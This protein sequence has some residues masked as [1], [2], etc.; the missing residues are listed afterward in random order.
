MLEEE[1]SDLYPS[2]HLYVWRADIS[3]LFQAGLVKKMVSDVHFFFFIYCNTEVLA[4]RNNMPIRL[5]NYRKC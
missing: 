4:S 5:C 1:D 2:I 3:L